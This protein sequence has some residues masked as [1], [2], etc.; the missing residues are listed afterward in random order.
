MFKDKTP[1]FFNFEKFINLIA[2]RNK[3][4]R[5]HYYI[6]IFDSNYNLD[7]YA[8]QQRFFEKLKKIKNFNLIACR[9]QKVKIDGKIVY[10]TKEDDIRLTLDMVKMI[11][12]YD[13]AILVSNDGDFV[14]VVEFLQEKG[15]IVEN[16][17]IGKTPSYY[18]RQVCNRFRKLS[19]RDVLK[20]LGN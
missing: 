1:D 19:K 7:G 20:L 13:T 6:G 5:T 8:S 18:L 16:I 11:D 17:G 9:M 10:Q 2:G 3:I 12:G 14:P 15:K 4:V